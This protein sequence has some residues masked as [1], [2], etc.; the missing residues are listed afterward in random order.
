MQVLAV[1]LPI[2]L[3]IGLGYLITRRGL[4]T[5][6]QVRGMGIFTVNVALPALIYRLLTRYRVQDVLEWRYV[7]VYAGGS[8]IVLLGS[9]LYWQ[10][11]AG[12]GRPSAAV[13][14]FGMA[15][16]NTGFI[17]LP[18][19]TQA[20]GPHVGV[21]LALTF[22]VENVLTLPGLLVLGQ[23]TGGASRGQVLRQIVLGL[24]RS[25]LFLAILAAV[26][27]IGS[28][29]HPIAPLAKAL[30]LLG[31]ASAPVALV[32]IGGSLV[33]LD[34][35]GMGS[36]V[37]RICVGKLVLHPLAVGAMLLLVPIADPDLR[38]GALLLASLPM[39]SSYPVF[40]QRYGEAPLAAAAL[41]ACTTSAFVTLNIVLWLLG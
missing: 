16:S 39:A 9:F 41:L 5:P 37:A 23:E 24:A 19:A 2:F 36:A 18:I 38:R 27:S 12:C 14:A 32:V 40:G 7:L 4:L 20:F 11:A 10:R 17:G 15:A 33:R 31:A 29:L 8:A 1:T 21:A 6:E 28:G 25:P 30:D 22:M 26:A 13:R 3:L 34:L 35:R